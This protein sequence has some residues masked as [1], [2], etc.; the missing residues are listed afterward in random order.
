MDHNQQETLG[1]KYANAYGGAAPNGDQWKALMDW[2]EYTPVTII[3][4]F[5]FAE[6]VHYEDE[7]SVS[8]EEA[9]GRYAAVSKGALEKAGGKFLM[10]APF[11]APF[12]GADESWDLV[13]IGQYP[14]KGAVFALFADENYFVAYSHRAKAC[15]KQCVMLTHS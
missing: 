7:G 14:D 2:P 9:F 5:R 11:G 10:V 15:R 4:F 13:A 12:I 8:G 1:R 6:A 3:N